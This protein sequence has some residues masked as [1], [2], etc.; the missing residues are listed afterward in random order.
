M[1]NTKANSV[2]YWPKF[3]KGTLDPFQSASALMPRHGAEDTEQSPIGVGQ[4]IGLLLAPQYSTQE[5]SFSM[6]ILRVGRAINCIL[7]ANEKNVITKEEASAL[8]TLV[9]SHF[10]EQRLNT[11]LQQLL[12]WAR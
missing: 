2:D 6:E 9:A 7:E 5:T 10:V 11:M 8:S 3:T 1:S 4:W 12:T